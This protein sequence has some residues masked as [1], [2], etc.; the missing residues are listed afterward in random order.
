MEGLLCWEI[1]DHYSSEERE[2]ISDDS[3]P[4]TY[5]EV[6]LWYEL[7]QHHM[8]LLIFYLIMDI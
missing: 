6:I 1:I 2:W 5:P 3:L 4:E 7:E 8:I